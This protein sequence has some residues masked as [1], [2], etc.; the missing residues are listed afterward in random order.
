M[1]MLM[2]RAGARE[3]STVA[4]QIGRDDARQRRDEQAADRQQRLGDGHGDM[5][6]PDN[7]EYADQQTEHRQRE[8][9][10]RRSAMLRGILARRGAVLSAFRLGKGRGGRHGSG[11]RR[12]GDRTYLM[13][14]IVHF[15]YVFLSNR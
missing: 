2:P 10:P 13:R 11:F 4:R 5:F 12:R 6:W 9:R 1:Q 8:Q 15:D 7:R 14:R 3:S